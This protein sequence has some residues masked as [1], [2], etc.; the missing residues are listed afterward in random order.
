M[1]GVKLKRRKITVKFGVFSPSV[2]LVQLP[3]KLNCS[4]TYRTHSTTSR[5]FS[6]VRVLK[7]APVTAGCLTLQL[8]A[9]QENQTLRLYRGA[10][11]R[12]G[13][14]EFSRGQTG[15]TWVYSNTR[16]IHPD[17][18]S[19]TPVHSP[20]AADPPVTELFPYSTT[21]LPPPCN[22][23]TSETLPLSSLCV[24]PVT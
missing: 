18:V 7:A 20:V 21:A 19:G 8:R 15:F 10:N 13:I 17:H 1:G 2:C 22:I 4:V 23:P 6:L 16:L 5:D 12:N 24:C 11:A 3:Q 14:Q 9:Q